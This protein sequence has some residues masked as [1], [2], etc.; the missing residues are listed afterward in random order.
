[1]CKQPTN[2]ALKVFFNIIIT[3]E[4]NSGQKAKFSSRMSRNTGGDMRTVCWVLV[5]WYEFLF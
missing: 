2:T 1:M 3:S 5:G 4:L